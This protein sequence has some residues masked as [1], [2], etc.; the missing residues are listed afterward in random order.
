[1]RETRHILSPG[2]IAIQCNGEERGGSV[3]GQGFA[4][5]F[6][7]AALSDLL[8]R[9]VEIGPAVMARDAAKTKLLAGYLGSFLELPAIEPDRVNDAI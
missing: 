6:S 8:G 3:D 7:R 5:Q 9:G 1:Q 2:D 4:I